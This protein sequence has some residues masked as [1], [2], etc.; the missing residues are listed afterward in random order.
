MVE[1]WKKKTQWTVEH[2]P[3]E[4]NLSKIKLNKILKTP[5]NYRR[6]FKQTQI[7]EQSLWSIPYTEKEMKNNSIKT[8]Q[9]SNTK[10]NPSEKHIHP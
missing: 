3:K 2:I 7:E 9:T 8:S 4:N 10:Q 6:R 1:T 5:K